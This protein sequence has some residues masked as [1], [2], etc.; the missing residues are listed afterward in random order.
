MRRRIFNTRF[1]K[2]V[3]ITAVNAYIRNLCILEHGVFGGRYILLRRISSNLCVPYPRWAWN[4][5][6]SD[7]QF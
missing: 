6:F 1:S 4:N 7:V 5:V 2:L 3:C